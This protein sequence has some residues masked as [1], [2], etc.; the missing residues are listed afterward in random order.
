M[1]LK[2]RRARICTAVTL[3]LASAA[4]GLETGQARLP[5]HVMTWGGFEVEVDGD[6]SQKS[7]SLAGDARVVAEGDLLPGALVT[8]GGGPHS[9]TPVVV[10]GLK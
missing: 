10:G 3:P 9:C 1:S 8:S 5:L 7:W 4:V 6:L 2:D